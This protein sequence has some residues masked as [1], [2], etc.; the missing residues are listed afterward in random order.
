MSKSARKNGLL[1]EKSGK[2]FTNFRYFIKILIDAVRYCHETG[3]I[4]RDIKVLL[5]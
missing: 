5:L 3:V 4:H 1:K 2:A